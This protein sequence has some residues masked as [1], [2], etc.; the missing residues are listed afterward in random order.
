MYIKEVLY[1]CVTEQSPMKNNSIEY[2]HDER[3]KNA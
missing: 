3:H 1:H 2:Y